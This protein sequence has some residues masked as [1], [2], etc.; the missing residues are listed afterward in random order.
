MSQA[1]S[2]FRLPHLQSSK[3]TLSQSIW[4]RLLQCGLV[5]A[6]AL[7]MLRSDAKP[8]VTIRWVHVQGWQLVLTGHSLGAGT[9]ALMSL[10]L[11]ERFPSEAAS[12]CTVAAFPGGPAVRLVHMLRLLQASLGCHCELWH[13]LRTCSW[14]M[15]N[16]MS[17][18]TGPTRPLWVH[19]CSWLDDAASA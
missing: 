2:C 9:A 19:L 4:S 8:G 11:K 1:F 12:P 5:S 3:T 10:K 13:P 17:L 7:V 18:V 6:H 14:W 15:L 16:P